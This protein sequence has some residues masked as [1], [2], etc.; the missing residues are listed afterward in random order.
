ML[1]H[2]HV[3]TGAARTHHFKCGIGVAWQ[4]AETGRG[5]RRCPTPIDWRVLT[6]HGRCSADAARKQAEMGAEHR[7]EMNEVAKSS[8]GWGAAPELLRFSSW[9]LAS[10]ATTRLLFI[11][12]SHITLNA[13]GQGSST[14]DALA[15]I[16]QRLLTEN[17]LPDDSIWSNIFQVWFQHCVASR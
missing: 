17:L 7:C 1:T 6:L 10:S 2:V 14:L 4:K 3:D 9:A 15:S 5:R 13:M 16:T 11:Q 12:F 8:R